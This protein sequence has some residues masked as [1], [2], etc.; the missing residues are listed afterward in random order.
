VAR[1]GVPAR[2]LP[3]TVDSGK[4]L[5]LAQGDAL[6]VVGSFAD[7]TVDAVVSDPP[8]EITGESW[9]VLPEL[10]T[11][12]EFVRVMKPGA[13]MVL[14]CA[15][16][17]YH[18]Q[19]LLARQAGL[20]FDAMW[21]WIY[22]T[23]RPS[24]G[25]L[26]PAFSPIC[27]FR[28]AGKRLPLNVAESRIPFADATDR[29][30]AAKA[31]S[32]A[33]ALRRAAHLH[34]VPD[35]AERGVGS[36]QP[37]IDGRYPSDV[38]MSDPLLGSESRYFHVPRVRDATAH[39]AAKPVELMAH[40][41]RLCVSE[42][43]VVLD[44]YAG[45]GSTGAAAVATGRRAILIERDESFA[46]S[47]AV[48]LGVEV[49]ILARRGEGT[50][51]DNELSTD[52]VSPTRKVRVP[53][54]FHDSRWDRGP[55]KNENDVLHH[56]LGRAIV[57]SQPERLLDAAQLAAALGCSTKTV[58][59]RT[60]DCNGFPCVRTGRLVR[61]SLAEVRAHI[62][63][64]T[65]HDTTNREPD[66]RVGGDPEPTYGWRTANHEAPHQAIDTTYR[67]GPQARSASK[68]KSAKVP[69][70]EALRS[71]STRL[72][73]AAETARRFSDGTGKEVAK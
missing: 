60:R 71:E 49:E 18:H 39:P 12:K 3:G 55:E 48:R 73:V 41:I 33:G 16:A 2:T 52:D 46:T 11:M 45:G 36:Y 54:E 13:P 5:R 63:M 27:V 34:R 23:G 66:N 10:C 62:D 67:R 42:G 69:K 30:R 68:P 65:S 57:S 31:R 35:R 56:S 61:Y 37:S 1:R 44:P 22:A 14:I 4:R 72:K 17:T 8:H 25:R 15:P 58:R 28:K 43:G 29:K 70:V 64:T 6:D 47:A 7:D 24:P 21:M 20:V 38:M 59:R 53:A 19:C 51:G 26:K 32:F 50:R 40:I 9:D